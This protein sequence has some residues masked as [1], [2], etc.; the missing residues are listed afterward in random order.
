M[1]V[2]ILETELE[3]Y[4]VTIEFGGVTNEKADSIYP[5]FGEYT[6]KLVIQF[7]IKK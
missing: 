5:F 1:C 6:N 3:F 7:N 4:G 2:N